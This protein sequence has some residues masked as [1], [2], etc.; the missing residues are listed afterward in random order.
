MGQ[1]NQLV[2]S[3]SHA[4]GDDVL[5]DACSVSDNRPGLACTRVWLLLDL[6]FRPNATCCDLVGLLCKKMIE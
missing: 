4:V 5:D 1:P 6:F 3:S 2:M